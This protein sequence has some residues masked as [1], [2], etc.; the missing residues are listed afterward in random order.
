MKKGKTGIKLWNK[1]KKIIPGGAQLF[2]KRA[3]NLLPGLWPTYY[4]KAKGCEIWDLDGHKYIDMSYMGL[5]ACILG[6]ADTDV[7]KAVKKAIKEGSMTTLNC[8][9]EVALAK[10]LCDLHPWSEMVRFARS[11]GEA[12][13]IAIRIARARTGKDMIL[14][15]GY[16]GWHD[17]YLA[18][19]LSGHNTLNGHTLKGLEPKGV[20]KGLKGTAATFYYN[21]LEGFLKSFQE[22]QNRIAAVVMEPVRNY[23]PKENFL[24]T[25][26][27]KTKK[28]GVVFIFD[29]ISSGW[30][31]NVGGVHLKFGINPDMAVFAKAMSNGYPMAAII[32]TSNVM[33]AA[34]DTFISSTYWSERIGPVAA[35]ATIDQLRKRNVP[36]HLKAIGEKVQEGWKQ[37][38]KKHGLNITIYGIPP[39]GHFTF[40][41]KNPAVKTLF[42]QMMLERGFLA[43]PAF[44]AS[45]AHKTKHI[46]KYLEAVDEV[47]SFIAQ[48]NKHGNF[49]KYLKGPVC[50]DSFSRLT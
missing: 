21:D 34:Q 23:S 9:E 26:R 12:M 8:P 29:E 50:Q 37:L 17:W 10:V 7:D 42:T 44:Y 33:E 22:Y 39:L 45:Y 41:D 1:A 24:E 5:G 40:Y 2:S 49:Y 46:N 47:F 30:R 14:F 32:G 25:I 15:C 28:S 19:N 31:Q 4:S 13:A 6:Y 36:R 48:V 43:T 35:L 18:A 16:H 3:E 11:G 38:G 20:P 27:E